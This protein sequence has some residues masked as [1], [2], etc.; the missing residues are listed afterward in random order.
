MSAVVLLVHGA[1]AETSIWADVIAMLRRERIE[2]IAVA[3][4]LSGLTSDATYVASLARSM[5]GPVVLGGHGYGGAVISAAAAENV[6]GLVYVAAFAPAVGETCVRL[7][8]PRVLEALRPGVVRDGAV[9]LDVRADAYAG[10]LGGEAA[11]QRPVVARAFDEPA[12]VARW[13]RV[14]SWFVVAARDAFLAPERQRAMAARAGGAVVEL[15]AAHDVA[16][17]HPRE[18]AEMFLRAT[19]RT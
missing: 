16:R 13:E 17:T 9:E 11:L 8:E 18:V 3:N 5:G 4:P 14:A 6:V 15:D 10:L 2:A 12:P 19:R 1:F 7:L